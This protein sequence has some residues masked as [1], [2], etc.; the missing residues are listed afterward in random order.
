[1]L[2]RDVLLLVIINVFWGSTDVVAKFALTEMSPG[3]LMWVRFSMAFVMFLP[4]LVIRR[5][6]IPL[7]I[8]SLA[9]LL[10]MGVCGF[11]LNHA[12]QYQG[13]K[14][15]QAS[16]STSLR[17]SESLL[18]VFLSWA[19][20]R[21]KIGKWAIMGLVGGTI[22]VAMVL[23]IDFGNLGLFAQG[24]R[25]GD[26]LIICGIVVEAFYTIIGK[27]ALDKTDPLLA[28]ALACTFGWVLLT[29]FYGPSVISEFSARFPSVN[30]FM[31]CAYLGLV[32]TFFGYTVYCV[33]LARRASHR[34]AMSIMIQPLSG[35]PLAALVY[36]DEMTVKFFFGAAMIMIGVYLALGRQMNGGADRKEDGLKTE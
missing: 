22:G 24:A 23:N 32:A 10:G 30:A 26:M 28:T 7:N 19:I 14:L 12:F 11:F 20:L 34:V 18:I 29:V 21:E 2:L 13:L 25:L 27:K 6:E 17:V 31:A 16:H 15:A 5:K 4:L 9:P 1:M 8:G 3:A 35:V 36:R 33:V